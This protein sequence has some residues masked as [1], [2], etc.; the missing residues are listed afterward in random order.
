MLKSYRNNNICARA[1]SLQRGNH[2]NFALVE[3]VFEK[4]D[5]HSLGA[6]KKKRGFFSEHLTKWGGDW[7]FVGCPKKQN[8]L[9]FVSN[10]MGFF[11][12]ITQG[13]F[14]EHS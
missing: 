12:W 3:G 1:S 11:V 7:P 13:F 9:F 8:P 5:H 4:K 14:V 6:Q 2:K 10:E